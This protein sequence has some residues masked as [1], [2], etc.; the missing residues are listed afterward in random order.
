MRTFWFIMLLILHLVFM[1]GFGIGAVSMILY[2]RSLIAGIVLGVLIILISISAVKLIIDF[3]K[4]EVIWL[5]E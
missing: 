4:G 2:P 5:E 3:K 1:A